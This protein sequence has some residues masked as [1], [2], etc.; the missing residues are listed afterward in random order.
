MALHNM[1][2]H[3]PAGSSDLGMS[4]GQAQLG[5]LPPASALASV[6]LITTPQSGPTQV[7]WSTAPL[8]PPAPL[9]GTLQQ[10]SL[11]PLLT[12]GMGQPTVAVAAGFCLSPAS[13]PFPPKLVE[14]VQSGQFV[15]M[16]ELLTDNISLLQQLDALNIQCALPA[17]PG[18]MKPRLREVTTLPSWV[19]CFLAYVAIR[20]SDP[21][22]RDMLAYGRL[23]IREAQ[24]HGGVGWLDYDKV[25]RQQAA[26]DST[27]KWNTIHPGMQAA[28]LTNRTSRPGLFCTSCREPDHATSDC[29]LSYLQPP[30]SQSIP[31]AG[32][33]RPAIGQKPRPSARRQDIICHSWNAGR[34][35]Y[36]NSCNFRH[37]CTRCHQQHRAR[38]CPQANE[39][40]A[41]ADLRSRASTSQAK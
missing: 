21:M 32:L 14:K 11:P 31:A 1:R 26:L 28:T 16:R 9:A 24:R 19:Y 29:A 36:P 17:L 33:S 38:D 2:T 15:E 40:G 41:R 12:G 4:V 6:P 8:L 20:S 13:E 30:L 18:L 25:F 3:L 35:M 39:G 37:V 5:I 22:T 10:Q 27:L 23:V 7:S 34:C